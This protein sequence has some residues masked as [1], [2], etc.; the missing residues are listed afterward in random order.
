MKGDH[1]YANQFE[2][3]S[4]MTNEVN[5]THLMRI[6]FRDLKKYEI[7]HSLSHE[8]VEPYLKMFTFQCIIFNLIGQIFRVLL[9]K[10][11]L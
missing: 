7:L 6:V 3:D 11:N 1:R 8:T 9:T 4:L 5:D 2:S 10:N